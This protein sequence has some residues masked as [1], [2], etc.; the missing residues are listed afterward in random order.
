[1]VLK[2]K[3]S[4]KCR[5]GISKKKEKM[6]MKHHRKENFKKKKDT[7]IECSVCMEEIAD[8]SD[9]VVTCGKV[10]HPLC[11]ECKLKCKDCPMCRS[12]SVKPPISQEVS[13][14]ILSSS[15]KV[16]DEFP[17]KMINVVC[18]GAFDH[19]S[20]IY[21]EIRKDKHN[22]PI[23]KKLD[24]NKFIMQLPVDQGGTPD[25][26]CWWKLCR[27]PDN[28]YKRCWIYKKGKLMGTHEW[29]ETPG[30]GATGEYCFISISRI[31]I[32]SNHLISV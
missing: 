27:S 29:H 22:Y 24:E 16:Q 1:M 23:Y 17:K 12:H 25:H 2:S 8:C 14:P 6:A 26:E 7:R 19:L 31:Y 5:S 9:N 13:I 32:P 30:R 21:H 28:G 20:G 10:N 18:S 4:K 15:N 11:G 3:G